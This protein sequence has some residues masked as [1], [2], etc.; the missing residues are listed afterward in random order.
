MRPAVLAA[1]LLVFMAASVGAGAESD[2]PAFLALLLAF[3]TGALAGRWIAVTFALIA[4][5]AFLLPLYAQG[6]PTDDYEALVV[7][8]SIIGTAYLATALLLGVAARKTAGRV[9]RR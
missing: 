5:P 3:A 2:A 6:G 1:A 9:R 8:L 7:V 4:V